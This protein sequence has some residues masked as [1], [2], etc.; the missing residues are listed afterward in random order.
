M[1]IVDQQ[2]FDKFPEVKIGVLK[3]TNIDNGGSNNDIKALLESQTKQAFQRLAPYQRCG[4]FRM[5]VKKRL[6]KQ[7]KDAISYLIKD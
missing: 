1:F 7:N 4:C 3:L 2:I 5:V 6:K